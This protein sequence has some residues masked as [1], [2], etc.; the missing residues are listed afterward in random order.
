MRSCSSRSPSN[1]FARLDSARQITAAA[2]SVT[3]HAAAAL[4]L[5]GVEFVELLGREGL[6]PYYIELA[7]AASA[8]GI[9]TVA[10]AGCCQHS[11]LV[12]M[13]RILDLGGQ[14]VAWVTF[15]QKSARGSI[16]GVRVATLYHEVCD[17]AMEEEIIEVAITSELEEVVAMEWGV[18]V[19]A[20]NYSPLGSEHLYQ[21][22]FVTLGTQG[23]HQKE[24]KEEN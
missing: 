8:L 7:S 5:V 19:E 9:G 21:R 6:A 17:D 3:A 22:T 13:G 2:A 23:K 18:V 20:Q 4:L 15:S 14:G 12:E 11:A 16:T 24:R 1:V 10:F